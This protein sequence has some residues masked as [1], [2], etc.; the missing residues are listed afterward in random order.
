MSIKE[1]SPDCVNPAQDNR[2][3]TR[4]LWVEGLTFLIWT[5]F[6]SSFWLLFYFRFDR[7]GNGSNQN[8]MALRTRLCALRSKYWLWPYRSFL[9]SDWRV[10][11]VIYSEAIGS[12]IYRKALKET[13]RQSENR[14]LIDPWAR[15][16]SIV[17]AELPTAELSQFCTVSVDKTIF[18]AG[19]LTVYG[20]QLEVFNRLVKGT[21]QLIE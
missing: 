12:D 15:Q 9:L 21:I 13:I 1:P 4:L 10:F 8:W 19:T 5:I 6:W 7:N 17:S 16:T 3:G 14:P 20:D 18:R 2:S 11:A